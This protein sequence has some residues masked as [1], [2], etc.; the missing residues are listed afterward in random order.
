VRSPWQNFSRLLRAT[1]K[2]C[3]RQ[4]LP[5]VWDHNPYFPIPSILE[6]ATALRSVYGWASAF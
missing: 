4:L 5:E 1:E 6:A 3:D 2:P